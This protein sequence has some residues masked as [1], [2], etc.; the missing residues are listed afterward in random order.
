MK[1]EVMYV[2]VKK[3][4]AIINSCQNEH[5]LEKTKKIVDDYVKTV[6]KQGVANSSDL[7]KRLYDELEQREEALYLV[8][9]LV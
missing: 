8:N 5:Q 1:K 6:S 3:I 2:P 7:K 4:L 9:L